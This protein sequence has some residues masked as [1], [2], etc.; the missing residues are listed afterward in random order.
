MINNEYSTKDS[1][2]NN[3]D[4]FSGSTN[5]ST[6]IK[7]TDYLSKMI[8]S[9]NATYINYNIN[10]TNN[11]NLI[12]N[13]SSKPQQIS[14]FDFG[15][16]QQRVKSPKLVYKKKQNDSVSFTNIN[17][18]EEAGS[19][20]KILNSKDYNNK[21]FDKTKVNSKYLDYRNKNHSPS[22]DDRNNF[23]SNVEYT[24]TV[25]TKKTN[26]DLPD[27]KKPYLTQKSPKNEK[28]MNELINVSSINS[29][30]RISKNYNDEPIKKE[31]DCSLK[32]NTSLNNIVKCNNCDILRDRIKRLEKNIKDKEKNILN[33]STQTT[34]IDVKKNMVERNSNLEIHPSKNYLN[35]KFDRKLCYEELENLKKFKN[36]VVKISLKLDEYNENIENELMTLNNFLNKLNKEK[37]TYI[38]DQDSFNKDDLEIRIR[39]G[40]FS[41]INQIKQ[42]NKIKQDEFSIILKE[43][44]KELN[45]LREQVDNYKKNK[46]KEVDDYYNNCSNEYQYTFNFMSEKE[47]EIKESKFDKKLELVSSLDNLLAL[48]FENKI[49][50][51]DNTLISSKKNTKKTIK[52][53]F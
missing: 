26:I 8:N 37:N 3:N 7:L 41:V 49:K 22:S 31:L 2:S 51:E 28:N 19:S 39:E 17:F 53:N 14:D 27:K 25:K 40:F 6:N 43:K 16:S 11:Q 9:D 44:E 48:E 20:R 35:D 18:E 23:S 47:K 34:K 36:K 13:I 45:N 24:F 42:I 10:T 4:L 50:N 30:N 32:I 52:K 46:F 1:N 33:S 21:K 38:I 15:Q 29:L 12:Y 5:A